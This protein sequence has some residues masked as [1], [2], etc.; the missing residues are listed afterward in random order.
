MIRN[1]V[2]PLLGNREITHPFFEKR[3][4]QLSVEQF[5]ELTIFVEENSS[6]A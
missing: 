2:Q 5:V 4:E 3:P 6:K 1:S